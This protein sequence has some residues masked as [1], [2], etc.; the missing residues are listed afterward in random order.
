MPDRKAIEDIVK[1]VDSMEGKYLNQE[2]KINKLLD[3]NGKL[4]IRLA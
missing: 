4:M 2:T 1:E 3:E